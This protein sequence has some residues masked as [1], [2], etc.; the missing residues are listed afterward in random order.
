M[1]APLGSF[2]KAWTLLYPGDTL[3]VMDGVYFERIAPDVRNGEPGRPITIRAQ[4]DGKAIIDGSTLRAQGYG[5]PDI[6]PIKIGDNGPGA[7]IGSWFVLEGL[8]ARN[9]FF[10]SV[11][12]GHASNNVLR[13]ISAYNAS[14]AANSQVFLVAWANNN[15]IEDCLVAG[16]GR[17]MINTF[18]SNNNTFRRCATAWIRWEGQLWCQVN[19]PNGNNIGVYN[20]STTTLENM[21]AY[22]RSL[23]G[24]F[25]QANDVKANAVGNRVFGSVSALNGRNYDNSRWDYYAGVEQPTS[26]PGPTTCQDITQWRWGGHRTGL[27]INGQGLVTDNVFQDN[28]SVDNEGLGVSIDRGFTPGYMPWERNVFNR[29]TAVGNGRSLS[30][31][32]RDNVF[33]AP[34]LNHNEMTKAGTF[35]LAADGKPVVAITNSKIALLPQPEFNGT[36]AILQEYINGQPTGRLL[37]DLD[38]PMQE[39]A[40]VEIGWDVNAVIDAAWQRAQTFAPVAYP[41][42][43]G[44]TQIAKP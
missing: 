18:G 25:V 44:G 32:E 34:N 5:D 31:P 12:V 21:V 11:R 8:I 35:V 2:A 37:A 14:A 23:N 4:N 39:R 38:W 9:G 13:R 41:A 29:I 43:N 16:T 3:I 17:Y 19:W 20:S 7:S 24:I 28:I 22:G 1:S 27:Q 42:V 33:G 30:Q 36:G 26:R 6:I 40:L 15:L 10:A